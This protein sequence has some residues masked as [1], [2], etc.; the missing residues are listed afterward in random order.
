MTDFA[1]WA[2]ELDREDRFA[3]T[4]TAFHIP[5]GLIYLDGNSLGLMQPKVT[6]RLAAVANGEWGDGLI[7]SWN[8]AGWFQLP[9][10]HHRFLPHSFAHSGSR[11]VDRGCAPGIDLPP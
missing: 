10:T 4:R 6:E 3:E 7:G 1:A 11:F 5:E 8:D 2:A 9:M